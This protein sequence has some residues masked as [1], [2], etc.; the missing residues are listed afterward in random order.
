V[1]D[2]QVMRH[3][4]LADAQAIGLANERRGIVSENRKNAVHAHVAVRVEQ[5]QIAH[6]FAAAEAVAKISAQIATHEVSLC[7]LPPP[8]RRFASSDT[9]ACARYETNPPGEHSG[10]F[11]AKSNRSGP[12]CLMKCS[13]PSLVYPRG[14]VS[15]IRFGNAWSSAML[16]RSAQ[17][18]VALKT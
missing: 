6:R 13:M 16:H 14:E 2:H 10:V 7:K 5:R 1:H 8:I 3:D 17:C 9:S 12:M 18:P 11:V 15:R 4:E